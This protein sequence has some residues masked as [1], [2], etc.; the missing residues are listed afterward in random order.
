MS[1]TF[2]RQLRRI[3]YS[4]NE[5]RGFIGVI[6]ED[7]HLLVVDKPAGLLS[8]SSPDESINLLDILKQDIKIQYNKPGTVYLALIHRL[9]RLVSG[10]MVFA[11]TSKAAARLSEQIREHKTHKTYHAIV[12][13]ILKVKEGVRED[14]TIK[15]ERV[16]LARPAPPGRGKLAKLNYR[17]IGEER[18]VK[19]HGDLSC[20]EVELLT[21][22][23]HQIRFQ[24]S[25]MGHPILGDTKYGAPRGLKNFGLGLRAVSMEIDHPVTKERLLFR[26]LKND[27]WPPVSFPAC[28]C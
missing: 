16:R 20:L 23:F 1:K 17:V 18:E 15:D 14:Y 5:E 3:E 6:Y 27:E 25:R 7:N 26:A 11:R 8:Q 21:G 22:R 9:D 19:L 12:T 10:V 13:G 28:R 4:Q 24:L 2:N